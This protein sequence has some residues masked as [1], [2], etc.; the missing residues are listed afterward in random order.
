MVQRAENFSD[1]VL[2]NEKNLRIWVHFTRAKQAI[3]TIIDGRQNTQPS[4]E[5]SMWC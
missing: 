3:F 4:Y 1:P 2:E 5:Q